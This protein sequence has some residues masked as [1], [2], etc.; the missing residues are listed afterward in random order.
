MNT[1]LIFIRHGESLQN[2]GDVK[3][4]LDSGLTELGWRQSM[5][6]ADW[7]ARTQTP[8][9][10]ISSTMRRA[11]QTADLIG[12]R[13]GLPVQIQSGLEEADGS[14]WN[15]LPA[16]HQTGP[17][18]LWDECWLPTA[19]NAPAY[20][21]FRARLR[22]ALDEILSA[23]D[24]KTIVIVSH[25]GSI[26]TILR[27]LFSGHSMPVFT[28]NTGVTQL[29]W[30]DGR[31]QLVAQNLQE[32]LSPF[33]AMRNSSGNGADSDSFPWKKQAGLQSVQAFYRTATRAPR[34][35][36][37]SAGSD[38]FLI[39][40]ASTQSGDAVLEVGCGSGALA[41]ALASRAGRVMGIDASAA[42][43]ER[44]ELK[45]IEANCNN[46]DL[47]WAEAA[48]LPIPDASLDLVASRDLWNHLPAPQ[49]YLSE[50]K[51][52]LRST[53]RLL[54][55]ELIG[56]AEPVKRATQEAIEVRRNP[57][58]AHLPTQAE[59]EHHLSD[60]SFKVT[61]AETYPVN[62]TL[63]D[64]LA[65]VAADENTRNEV[66]KMLEAGM[67]EDAAGLHV[68]RHR[69]GSITFTQQRL[70]LLAVPVAPSTFNL[71]Q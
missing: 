66:R 53:G 22:R 19:E 43:L 61:Q 50:A 45:R 9:I 56:S 18:S 4:E 3:T 6:V 52:V 41:L 49:T 24:G 62:L 12:R 37:Q 46:L 44:A 14:Y 10:V 30:K 25:G 16:A 57:S 35:E 68:H 47:T 5:L 67:E 17:L 7:L 42:M 13:L 20:T 11:R 48:D 69:D 71:S 63:A 21:E 40:L 23:Y 39:E 31:W 60:A 29:T 64:W 8:D 58:F 32:H 34:G 38:A 33:L 59:I 36:V 65:E 1:T 51:R 27:S 55:D 54:L 28:Q 2:R 70:R 15:E 26:G